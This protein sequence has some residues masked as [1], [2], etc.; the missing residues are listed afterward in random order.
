MKKLIQMNTFVIW[1]VVLDKVAHYVLGYVRPKKKK[2]WNHWTKRRAGF[3]TQYLLYT[4]GNG[5]LLTRQ[6]S[7][8]W[9]LRPSTSHQPQFVF[10]SFRYSFEWVL[11]SMM[12]M[13]TARRRVLGTL[14]KR[15]PWVMDG[16]LLLG[17]IPA[18][19]K[20]THPYS[21]MTYAWHNT[22][23]VAIH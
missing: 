10:T 3:L 21:Y 1:W 12:E 13:C 14:V 9:E 16:Q 5:L 20:D 6:C 23:H 11:P 4:E 8:A 2:G 17:T 19:G 22:W 15:G 18:L 7:P